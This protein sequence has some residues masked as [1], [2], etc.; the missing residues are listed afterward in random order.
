MKITFEEYDGCFNFDLE[1]ETIADA[2]LLARAAMNTTQ[3]TATFSRSGTVNGS[4]VLQ[5]PRE[6]KRQEYLSR[7][8]LN[9]KA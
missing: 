8:S 6:A 2:A 1:A 7:P 3:I 9:K 5:K 4:L